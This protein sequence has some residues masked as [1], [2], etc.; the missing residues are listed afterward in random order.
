MRGDSNMV[1]QQG[2]HGNDILRAHE[3]VMLFYWESDVFLSFVPMTA[4]G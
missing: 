2:R 4:E 1:P 3:T